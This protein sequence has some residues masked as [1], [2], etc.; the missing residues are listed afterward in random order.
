[1]I[2]NTKEKYL[3]SALPRTG[4]GSIRSMLLCYTGSV[5]IGYSHQ[6]FIPEKYKNYYRFCIIRNPYQRLLSLW[7]WC[8]MCDKHPYGKG[9]NLKMTFYAFLDR[10]NVNKNKRDYGFENVCYWENQYN[11]ISIFKPHLILKLESIEI[12]LQKLPFG[13]K[14]KLSKGHVTQ[15]KRK[16]WKKYY[17]KS[18]LRLANKHSEKDFETY[19]YKRYTTVGDMR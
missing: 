16:F 4:G 10:V 8:C 11:F 3:F 6:T 5:K 14:H 19:G 17:A 13:S 18:T 15:D 2:V 12:D 9:N 7:W 1:M